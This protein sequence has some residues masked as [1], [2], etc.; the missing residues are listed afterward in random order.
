[1]VRAGILGAVRARRRASGRSGSERN[2]NGVLEQADPSTVFEARIFR[3]LLT[4]ASIYQRG[5][6]A[7]ILPSRF[8]DVAALAGVTAR[9][10]DRVLSEE[11][12]RGTLRV[13]GD[14][15]TI[16]DRSSLAV[17]SAA[18][19]SESAAPVHERDGLA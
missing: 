4:L 16:L 12:H 11:A 6:A 9:T 19:R 18:G 1:M 2:A 7:I 14:A 10:V 3:R 13:S 5:D 17:R 8:A 15:I